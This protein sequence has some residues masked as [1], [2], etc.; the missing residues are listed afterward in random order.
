LQGVAGL[1]Q[2][3]HALRATCARKQADLDLGQT[4]AGF[5]VVRDHA[6]VAGE[7]ELERAA[8]ADAVN[9]RRERLAAGFQPP[10]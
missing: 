2:P 1:H 10:V 5:F 6:V 4:D 3:R 9:R 7:R 8:E